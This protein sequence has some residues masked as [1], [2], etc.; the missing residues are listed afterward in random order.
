MS[1][2]V[3]GPNSIRSMSSFMD[4]GTCGMVVPGRTPIRI[5]NGSIEPSR[6]MS[7]ESSESSRTPSVFNIRN[8]MV[9]LPPELGSIRSTARPPTSRPSAWTRVLPDRS[10]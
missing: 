5:G 10:K 2:S 8:A 4:A 1:I 3:F 9:V 7:G 6:R